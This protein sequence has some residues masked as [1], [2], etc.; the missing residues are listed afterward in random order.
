MEMTEQ[1]TCGQGLAANAPLPVRLGALTAALADT[2]E[3]HMGALDLDDQHARR[4][5][6]VYRQLADRH[7]QLADRLRQTGEEMAG[8]RDLPMGRHDRRVM[9][10][11]EAVAAFE[12]F[13]A[14]ERE[15]LALLGQRLQQDQ[16]M[17]DEMGR[18]GGR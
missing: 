6:D 8:Q 14:A 1:P 10:S 5:Y 7:R 12:R 9:A 13:V 3:V 15:L 2:L 11:P 4:E 18:A 16:R 17:L